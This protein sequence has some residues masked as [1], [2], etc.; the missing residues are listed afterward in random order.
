MSTV[1]FSFF[2]NNYS[3]KTNE[4]F[5]WSNSFPKIHV[6]TSLCNLTKYREFHPAKKGDLSSARKL[7]RSCTKSSLL[8]DIKDRYPGAYLIPVIR[9]NCIPGA[10][11]EAIG[12]PICYDIQ[13]ADTV[14]RKTLSGMERLIHIPRF[15]GKITEGKTYVIV[16]DVVTQGGTVCAL[17]NHIMSHGGKVAAV[18]ALACTRSNVIAPDGMTISRIENRFDAALWELMS[19]YGLP[20]AS[21]YYTAGQLKYLL[22]FSG[23][24]SVKSKLLFVLERARFTSA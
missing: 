24:P 23:V 1:I 9:N 13:Y 3:M 5:L 4:Y 16:D 19:S 14:S 21:G 6:Q 15:K 7:I 18:A 20:G 10:F 2:W 11:A 8:K 17:R 22:T 12:L